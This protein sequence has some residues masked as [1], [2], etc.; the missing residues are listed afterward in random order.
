MTLPD[1][2]T[3]PTPERRSAWAVRWRLARL[4]IHLLAGLLL[5]S[6]VFPLVSPP[7]HQRLKAYWARRLLQLLGVELRFTG[8]IPAG[9]LLVANHTSWL[10]I[11]VISAAHPSTFVAKSEIRRWPML[12][13][14]AKQIGTLFIER[15]RR[16]HAGHIAHEMASRLARGETIAV[17]PEGTTSDG[18]DV[19]PFHAALFQPAIS[20]A[21]PVTALSIRYRDRSGTS[22]DAASYTG[23]TTLG[24][25][26]R[27]ILSVPG[28]VAELHVL[29][30]LPEEA[31]TDRRRLARA[32]EH[33]IRQ[34]LTRGR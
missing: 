1:R 32:A 16:H 8:K 34:Q 27:R 25:S 3:S 4:T 14:L 30:A 21:R 23:D 29:P 11:F 26:L 2:F 19:L 9:G 18:R 28:I 33:A 17:F 6:L 20:A 7:R 12:G 31:T 22:T 10:D 15:S 24:E 5:V 13:W